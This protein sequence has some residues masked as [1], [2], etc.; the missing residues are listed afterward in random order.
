MKTD[1]QTTDLVLTLTPHIIRIP[2]ITEEDLTPVYV[3]TDANISYQGGPRVENPNRDAGPFE[4]QPGGRAPPAQRTPPAAGQPPANPGI[5]LAPGG[6]PTDIFRPPTQPPT[7]SPQNQIPPQSKS[8][9]NASA[10]TDS[11]SAAALSFSAVENGTPVLL[12]FD[13]AFLTI[14][15]GQQQTVLVRATS[16]GGFPGG[17]LRVRFDPSVAAAVS[18]R[19]ILTGGDGTASASI[20]GSEVILELPDSA[21]LSGTRAVAEITFRGIVAGRGTVAFQPIEMA[22]AEV[23]FSTAVV[24]VR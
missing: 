11:A 19:P 18:V 20:S 7:S 17:T 16:P 24:D 14:G 10:G 13:P 3:G 21:D 6:A 2:D 12:D 4:Q 22:G 5:N 15:V 1:N 8:G 9:Q 23:T